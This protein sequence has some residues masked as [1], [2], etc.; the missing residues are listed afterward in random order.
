MYKSIKRTIDVTES[1]NAR[2]K[3][4]EELHSIKTKVT[5]WNTTL[6]QQLLTNTIVLLLSNEPTIEELLENGSEFGQAA[7]LELTLNDMR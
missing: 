7:L 3:I 1:Q 4:E 2:M 5:S 6:H